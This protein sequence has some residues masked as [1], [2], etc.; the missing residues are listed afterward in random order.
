ME[1]PIS[2]QILQA[3]ATLL[4]GIVLGLIYDVLRVIRTRSG[5]LAVSLL[6]DLLFCLMAGAALFLLGM[7][8]GGGE[9]RL[10]MPAAAMAGALLYLWFFGPCTRRIVRLT[11][12]GLRRAVT[13]LLFPLRKI[14]MAVKKGWEISKNIF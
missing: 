3:A 10:Y 7:G 8:P 6:A 5:A 14:C 2:G 12:D 13:V 11:L 4:A 1:N 9:L